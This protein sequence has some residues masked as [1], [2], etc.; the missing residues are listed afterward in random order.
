MQYTGNLTNYSPYRKIA[1]GMGAYQ[2]NTGRQHPLAGGIET[3]NM[4][5]GS[6]SLIDDNNFLWY[7]TIS[8]GTPPENFTGKTLLPP[9]QN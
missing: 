6:V 3:S 9:V 5:A 8:I 4:Q 1:R 7:G 2:R